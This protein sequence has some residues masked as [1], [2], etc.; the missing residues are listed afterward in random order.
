MINKHVSMVRD[1]TNDIFALEGHH[2][3]GLA[4][5]R[6]N[7][8]ASALELR[9]SHTNPSICRWSCPQLQLM[10]LIIRRD[11]IINDEYFIPGSSI[12]KP[13]TNLTVVGRVS[14]WGTSKARTLWHGTTR[15]RGVK[16]IRKFIWTRICMTRSRSKST[17]DLQSLKT[18][19]WL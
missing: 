6:R 18:W 17:S 3:H 5:E 9:I 8:S 15:N 13:D 7:S 14:E 1:T 10:A 4:Y 19:F 12:S 2:I 11:H 16:I